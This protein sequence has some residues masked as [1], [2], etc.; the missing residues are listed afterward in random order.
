MTAA[1]NRAARS[2]NARAAFAGL[3]LWVGVG[4]FKGWVFPLQ[5]SVAPVRRAG[6]A[7]P[8]E[9]EAGSGGRWRYN[10]T[11]VLIQQWG[12]GA[13]VGTG[14]LVVAC[15]V[16]PPAHPPTFLETGGLP[17]YPRRGL[18]PLHPAWGTRG[19][20]LCGLGAR[21]PFLTFP[22]GRGQGHAVPPAG[23]RPCTPSSQ[24]DADFGPLVKL[25]ERPD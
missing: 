17:L 15:A 13:G 5:L 25:R 3:L 8:S 23:L 11:K 1:R 16:V 2:A 19:A 9:T 7:D 20:S 18:R 10:S 24:P 12:A 21:T 14:G 22:R 4:L 6:D